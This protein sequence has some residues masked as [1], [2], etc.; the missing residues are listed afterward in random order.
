MPRALFTLLI[1][2]VLAVGYLA[3]FQHQRA[4]S[5]IVEARN[6]SEDADRIRSDAEGSGRAAR[7]AL[8]AKDRQLRQLREQVEE[9]REAGARTRD[10]IRLNTSVQ[11]QGDESDL[12]MVETFDDDDVSRRFRMQKS[13]KF[14]VTT[15]DNGRLLIGQ[16]GVA[17]GA[18]DVIA[19]QTFELPMG[20]SVR[21]H[22]SE[23]PRGMEQLRR[24]IDRRGGR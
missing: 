23:R 14:H 7:L 16:A 5:A 17:K 15:V 19:R 2:A 11:E 13:S 10:E 18:V 4:E 8:A 12:I 20:A 21:V 1:I 3:Y 22:F 9:A 24:D 6:A